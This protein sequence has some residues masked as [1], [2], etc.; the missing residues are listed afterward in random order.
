MPARLAPM[1]KAV[2]DGCGLIR[3]RARLAQVSDCRRW[4]DRPPGMCK[5]AHK[6][7]F[8]LADRAAHRPPRSRRGPRRPERGKAIGLTRKGTPRQMAAV[9]AATA[10]AD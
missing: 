2:V 6:A 9:F 8:K 4:S 7:V 10:V 1:V 5:L 3:L